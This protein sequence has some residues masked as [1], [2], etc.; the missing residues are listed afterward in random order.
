[1]C[2]LHFC[3]FLPCVAPRRVAFSRAEMGFNC[4]VS[5]L[6]VP[7]SIF[8]ALVY[9]GMRTIVDTIITFFEAWQ[10]KEMERGIRWACSWPDDCSK[11]ACTRKRASERA[12]G[13]TGGRAH[14]P[15][16]K[17]REGQLRAIV[18]AMNNRE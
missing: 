17:A 15:D 13:R 11:D 8:A 16:R 1:M 4:C 7:T 12:V 3:R 5:H 2:A 6:L 14:A 18:A 10:G 9:S